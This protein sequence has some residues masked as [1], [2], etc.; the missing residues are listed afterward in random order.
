MIIGDERGVTDIAT[1]SDFRFSASAEAL[2]D[3]ANMLMQIVKTAIGVALARM[4]IHLSSQRAKESFW[5]SI[6]VVLDIVS[7]LRQKSWS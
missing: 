3:S 2:T 6:M 7:M 5:L 1:V 4:N